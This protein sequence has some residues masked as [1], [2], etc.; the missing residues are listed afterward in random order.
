MAGSFRLLASNLFAHLQTRTEPKDDF[1]KNSA[2]A[3]A[4]HTAVV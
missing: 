2:V 1:L 3:S 4:A